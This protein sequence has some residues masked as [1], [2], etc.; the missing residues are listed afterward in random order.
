MTKILLLFC[1]AFPI[2]S[3]AQQCPCTILTSVNASKIIQDGKT[4]KAGDEIAS[5][6]NLAVDNRT[7]IV[8]IDDSK[9]DIFYLMPSLK[10]GIKKISSKNPHSELYGIVLSKYLPD[11]LKSGSGVLT[12]KS[13]DFDW[14]SYFTDFDSTESSYRLLIVEGERIP[15]NSRFFPLQP[16]QELFACIYQGKDSVLKKLRIR[17]KSLIL[18]SSVFGNKAIDHGFVQWKLKI[19]GT[20]N[21]KKTVVDISPRLHSLIISFATFEK[22]AKFVD[23]DAQ[24]REKRKKIVQ[25]FWES[26]YGRFNPMNLDQVKFE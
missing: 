8:K 24:S 15:L 5:T 22:I 2:L 13:V 4:L 11:V 9:G 21:D 20:V 16:D 10:E 18:D 19:T 12:T 25:A 17:D 6:K 7:A 1:I 26:S 23:F 14:F 3:V